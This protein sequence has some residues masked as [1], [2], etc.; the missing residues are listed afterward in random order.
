[1]Q[2]LGCILPGCKFTYD[3]AYGF[4][5]YVLPGGCVLPVTPGQLKECVET[6]YL[7]LITKTK[8]IHELFICEPVNLSLILLPVTTSQVNNPPLLALRTKSKIGATSGP[9]KWTLVQQKI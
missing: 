9:T 5:A 2:F 7:S 4:L 3:Q 8:T 6:T 1:M